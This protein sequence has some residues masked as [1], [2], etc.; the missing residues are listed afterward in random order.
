MNTATK[1]A[2]TMVMLALAG[3]SSDG[4]I[5][6]ASSTTPPTAMA[7][8]TSA[9]APVTTPTEGAS[10]ATIAQYA[11]L[12]ASHEG[13]WRETV[14]DIDDTCTDPDAIPICTTIYLTASYQA[15]T[16][17]LELSGAAD[18]LGEPSAE[19]AQL[20]ADTE[21]AAA[22]YVAAYHAWDATGCDDPL[23]LECGV[24]ESFEMDRALDGLTR[25][26]DAW[27]P[28]TG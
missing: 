16:L 21:T 6:A 22:D 17:R 1:A 4:G 24:S 11:S 3:C 7:T 26:F 27:S 9:V 8:E 25:Q 15:E 12:V 5:D 23:D 14:A 13:E 10:E 19:I 18:D 2:I 28:Y 20:V